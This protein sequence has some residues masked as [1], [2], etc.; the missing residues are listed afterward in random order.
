LS[1]QAGEISPEGEI[2][3]P[4]VQAVVEPRKMRGDLCPRGDL[5]PEARE[6]SPVRG[7]FHGSSITARA[8]RRQAFRVPSRFPAGRR[9]VS[10]AGRSR[11]ARTQPGGH[12]LRC[13]QR[14][15][16]RNIRLPQLQS[17]GSGRSLLADQG[18]LRAG[19]AVGR[20]NGWLLMPMSGR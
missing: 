7:K 8:R 5:N 15:G 18:D 10:G 13:P 1:T 4:R 16:R 2:A 20:A 19:S 14:P 17:H 3:R 11:G 12:A 9:A 6:I